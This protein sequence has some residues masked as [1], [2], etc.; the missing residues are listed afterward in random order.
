MTD[1]H[2]FT[3]RRP[4]TQAEGRCSALPAIIECDGRDTHGSDFP[5]A[6]KTKNHQHAANRGAECVAILTKFNQSKNYAAGEHAGAKESEAKHLRP[7][8]EQPRECCP[9]PIGTLAGFIV[10]RLRIT[11]A[12]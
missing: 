9:Q 3:N 2:T 1:T 5:T 10:A 8:S 4:F 6:R 11:E 7:L 12:R